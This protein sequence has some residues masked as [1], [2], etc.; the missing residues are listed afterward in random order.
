[1][2][3]ALVVALHEGRGFLQDQ[4]WHQTAKLM[5]LAATEI[6]RLDERVREL[7]DK[8]R[9]D[10]LRIAATRPTIPPSLGRDSA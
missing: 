7:E 10:R 4:G 6:E 3:T 8:A 5:T 9:P 1:M 2:K